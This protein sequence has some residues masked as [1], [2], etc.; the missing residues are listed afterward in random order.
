M[1]PKY[2]N[3]GANQAKFCL[4]IVERGIATNIA[5]YLISK[6]YLPITLGLLDSVLC[7]LYSRIKFSGENDV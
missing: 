1:S 2:I 7:Y 5:L 3:F 6:I 4:V